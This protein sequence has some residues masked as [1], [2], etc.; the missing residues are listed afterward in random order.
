MKRVLRFV[1]RL[2]RAL[3][4]IA[5]TGSAVVALQSIF[6][7][8]DTSKGFWALQAALWATVVALQDRD[9]RKSSSGHARL[10]RIITDTDAR[11]IVVDMTDRNETH[12]LYR[13]VER[14]NTEE[15]THER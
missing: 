3:P 2:Q 1:D 14:T 6:I 15:H 11:T 8:G 13:T 10:G 4:I 12:T 9:L 7:D 5:A